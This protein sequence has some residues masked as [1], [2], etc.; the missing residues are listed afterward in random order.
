MCRMTLAFLVLIKVFYVVVMQL[1][2]CS[3]LQMA[4]R[5]LNWE[6]PLLVKEDNNVCCQYMSSERLI[7]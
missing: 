3:N 7:I 4:R 6:I 1:T 5:L 2:S